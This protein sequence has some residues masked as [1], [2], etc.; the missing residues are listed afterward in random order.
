[1]EV[2]KRKQTLQ[3]QRHFFRGEM[4][5]GGPSHTSMPKSQSGEPVRNNLPADPE[6]SQPA[7]AL[8]GADHS[9]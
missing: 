2:V 6:P 5:D 8:P 1:V 9:G 3:I 7:G 4:D